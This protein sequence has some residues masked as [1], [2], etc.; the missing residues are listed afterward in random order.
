MI[1]NIYYRVFVYSTEDE[2][3]VK[4]ALKNIL[5]FAEPERKIIEGTFHN[6]IIILSER[7]EKKRNIKEFIKNLKSNSSEYQL[8][9]IKR[10]L[11]RKMDE[12]GNLFLRFDKQLAYNEKWKS[13]DDGDSIHLKI[14]IA[15]YPAK[16]EIAL[17]IAN[18][19]FS[20]DK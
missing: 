7:I 5:P 11:D 1:H 6:E 9:I 14:K 4:I 20:T 18:D 13:V 10:N 2:E 16:K 19:I 3:K 15:A 8:D 17:D 12:N